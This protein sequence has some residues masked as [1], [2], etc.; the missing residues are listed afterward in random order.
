M[1]GNN[2]MIRNSTILLGW[3]LSV[4]IASAEPPI[5]RSVAPAPPSE[6][7]PRPTSDV[8]FY[9]MQSQSRDRQDRDRYEC[10]S[11]ARKQTGYDP[12]L[13][14]PDHV[15]PV[16]VVAVPPPGASVAGGTV[17]GAVI[18][19]SVVRPRDA[20]QGAVVGAIAG[21]IVGAAAGDSRRA[22]ANAEEQRINAARQADQARAD[23][24]AQDYRRAMKA[25]LEG[26]GYSVQ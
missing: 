7:Q 9:P 1:L 21:A 25:C 15:R 22:Q 3:L 13:V 23:A 10:S 26:R 6:G 4:S 8:Y 24:H 11:W 17:A 14:H 18:G 12:S 20:G 19:A 2:A 5:Y 16:H